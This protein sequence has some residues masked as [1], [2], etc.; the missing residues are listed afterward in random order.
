MKYLKS[1]KANIK[2]LLAA[3]NYK[4]IKAIEKEN[5]NLNRK[6]IEDWLLD[7]YN[8][9]VDIINENEQELKL[10][11][12]KVK[13]T[14]KKT[15]KNLP[16][17]ETSKESESEKEEKRKLKQL[18]KQMYNL[19]IQ[20]N[21]FLLNIPN[22]IT[23]CLQ[24]IKEKNET[25]T[26]F[27]FRNLFKKRNNKVNSYSFEV[28]SIPDIKS[29]LIELYKKQK[30]AFKISIQFGFVFEKKNYDENISIF[31][32]KAFDATKNKFYK[33][34]I[35]ITNLKQLQNLLNSFN[36]DDIYSYVDSMR[37]SSSDKLI[38][39]TTL[40]IK[41]FDMNYRIGSNIELPDYIIKNQN[42]NSM[43]DSTNN[44]CF[45]NCLAFHKTKE[46]KCFS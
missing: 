21:L 5:P 4:S 14:L 17:F 26:M 46:R 11:E 16:N 39:I 24:A 28:H 22:N 45:W 41:L 12:K 19:S 33:E 7:N 38:A 32:Y 18:K 13:N 37:L 10:K 15:F 35:L 6:Q 29:K 8:S 23:K 25:D 20:H 1:V 44:M 34:A 3:S 30:N 36:I 43:C 27:S 9:I 40:D 2:T 42:I 31:S